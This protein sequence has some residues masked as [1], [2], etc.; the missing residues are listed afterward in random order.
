MYW[1]SL[2]CPSVSSEGRRSW[3]C[4]ET[5]DMTSRR[6]NAGALNVIAHCIQCR[7]D[8]LTVIASDNMICVCPSALLSGFFVIS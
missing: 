6:R 8:K 7:Q 4:T 2:G 5:G 1:K 3:I